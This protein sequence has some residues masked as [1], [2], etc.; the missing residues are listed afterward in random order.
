VR[1]GEW[2]L[3]P[4]DGTV[5][6]LRV[7]ADLNS[8]TAIPCGWTEKMDPFLGQ[9]ARANVTAKTTGTDFT[10]LRNGR[11]RVF[12]GFEQ[13]GLPD[14]VRWSWGLAMFEAVHPPSASGPFHWFCKT[15]NNDLLL[16]VITQTFAE[17]GFGVMPLKK[18]GL[19][20]ARFDGGRI[21]EDIKQQAAEYLGSKSFYGCKCPACLGNASLEDYLDGKAK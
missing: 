21:G 15:Y 9:I 18:G 13:D 12:P 1:P 11:L 20:I 17:D 10:E 16:T 2:P 19:K 7:R 5:I 8:D 3:A 14:P 4:P 6:R